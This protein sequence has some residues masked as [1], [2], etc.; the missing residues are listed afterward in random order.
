MKGLTHAPLDGDR[1]IRLERGQGQR[2][3]VIAEQRRAIAGIAGHD[4]QQHLAAS[5]EELATRGRHAGHYLALVERA[6]PHLRGP[7]QE[8]WFAR[9]EREHDNLRAALAWYERNGASVML[10][11]LCA[12]SSVG[13]AP[14]L[15]LSRDYGSS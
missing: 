1:L 15:S 9:L 10:A 6:E 4:V 7:Q 14:S 12:E 3:I 8:A 13:A 2:I 11:R 5:G